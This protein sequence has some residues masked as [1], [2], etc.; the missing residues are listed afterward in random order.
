[1]LPQI[2]LK[3]NIQQIRRSELDYLVY[4]ICFLILPEEGGQNKTIKYGKK[5]RVGQVKY[6]VN[7]LNHWVGQTK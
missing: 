3:I 4:K 2:D 5:I 6:D 7:K 1:M